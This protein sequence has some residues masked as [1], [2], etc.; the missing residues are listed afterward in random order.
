MKKDRSI[1]MGFATSADAVSF[2]APQRGVA[3]A[4]QTASTRAAAYKRDD[5]EPTKEDLEALSKRNEGFP[6]I[7]P[8]VA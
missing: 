3:P 4:R 7:P 8:D 6:D 2:Q 5:Q 1:K